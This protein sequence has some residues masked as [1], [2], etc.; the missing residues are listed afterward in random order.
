MNFFIRAIVAALVATLLKIIDGSLEFMYL[1]F[2]ILIWLELKC[3][4]T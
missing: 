4:K 1:Y 2:L 3:D